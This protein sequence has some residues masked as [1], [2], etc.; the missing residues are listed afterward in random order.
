MEGIFKVKINP[1]KDSLYYNIVDVY[2]NDSLALLKQAYK[3]L[4]QTMK[5]VI[6]SWATHDKKNNIIYRVF[7]LLFDC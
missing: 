3:D 6:A 7:G 2:K 5:K 4:K 1:Y